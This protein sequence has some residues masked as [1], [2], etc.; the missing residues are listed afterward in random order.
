MGRPRRIRGPFEKSER[1]RLNRIQGPS[2]KI[3]KD[4]SE[5]NAGGPS[6]GKTPPFRAAGENHEMGLSPR[7]LLLVDD[8][9]AYTRII[10]DFFGGIG[11]A[12]DCAVTAREG[13]LMLGRKGLDHYRVVVT[14][15]TME[16]QLAGLSV[17]LFLL[18]KKFSGTV[19]MASTGFDVRLGMFFSKLFM[20]MLGVHYLVPKTTILKEDF[21]FYPA[22][23]FSRPQ[24]EFVEIGNGGPMGENGSAP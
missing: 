3:G 13:I 2:E 22:R 4:P 9:A 18:R 20:G 7:R 19:V 16:H 1:G 21:A 15:I 10:T 23:L 5:E 17:V 12:V 24:K 8:R 11:Y 6:E 14:D